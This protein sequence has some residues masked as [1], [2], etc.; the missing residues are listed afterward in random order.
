MLLFTVK[1]GHL[2]LVNY[3]NFYSYFV[4]RTFIIWWLHKS[5]NKWVSPFIWKCYGHFKK[6]RQLPSHSTFSIGKTPLLLNKPSKK[7]KLFSYL[8]FHKEH[9]YIYKAIHKQK[10]GCDHGIFHFTALQILQASYWPPRHVKM[11]S[12]WPQKISTGQ[13]TAS[14]CVN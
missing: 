4:F 3:S 13:S 9:V 2:R 12:Y 5:N 14:N 8:F 10:F 7:F 6:Q 1:E 11:S